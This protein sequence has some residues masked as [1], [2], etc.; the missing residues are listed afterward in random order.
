MTNQLDMQAIYHWDRLAERVA[1]NIRDNLPLQ[2]IRF[3]PEPIVAEPV[4]IATDCY[5]VMILYLIYPPAL[6]HH[7]GRYL[8][9][10]AR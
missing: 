1:A 2:N 10:E 5:R 9:I 6:C 3:V 4:P 7:Q 8:R